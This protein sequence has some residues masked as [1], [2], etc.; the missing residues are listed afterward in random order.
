MFDDA[1]A[2][3]ARDGADL[4][5]V[6][7][8]LLKALQALAGLGGPGFRKA[9]LRHAQAALKRSEEKLLLE[10]EKVR[11]RD[12]VREMEGIGEAVEI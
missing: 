12:I 6:Q 11:L 9:A 10:E 1:F 5:E 4:L 7:L 3:I 8:R 2:P